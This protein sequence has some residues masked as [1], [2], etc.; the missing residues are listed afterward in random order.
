[1]V[2][3]FVA[4]V[5]VEVGMVIFLSTSND[6]CIHFRMR[7]TLEIGLVSN[8]TYICAEFMKDEVCTVYRKCTEVLFVETTLI[9]F[10]RYIGYIAVR[11]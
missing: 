8:L 2:F 10:K 11:P 6:S 5:C 4:F 7:N 3:L 1:M 9:S